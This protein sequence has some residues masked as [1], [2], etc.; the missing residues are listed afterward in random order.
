MN[1]QRATSSIAGLFVLLS[2]GLAAL[3]N[4]VD[5]AHPTWLWFTIFVGLNLFQSG[6][7]GWCLMTSIL[8]RIGLK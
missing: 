2:V 3:Y 5:L 8:R 4:S 6:L 7:T 1:A